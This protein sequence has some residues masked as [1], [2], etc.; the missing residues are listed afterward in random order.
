MDN[1]DVVM[2]ANKCINNSTTKN[3]LLT[4]SFMNSGCDTTYSTQHVKDYYISIILVGALGFEPRSAGVFRLACTWNSA[5]S[6][7]ATGRCSS[8]SSTFRNPL[9]V[10]PVQLEPAVLPGYTIPPRVILRTYVCL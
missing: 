3:E 6:R 8:W 2:K 1:G 5:R 4:L 10:I 7:V 9:V